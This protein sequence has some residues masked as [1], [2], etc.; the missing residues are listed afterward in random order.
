MHD[1][2]TAGGPG[3][4][5]AHRGRPDAVSEEPLAAAQDHGEDNQAVG[6]D[7][8]LAHEGAGQ[9]AAAV[10]LQFPTRR[11][12]EFAN[13]MCDVTA[14]SHRTR[15]GEVFHGGGHDML[16]EGVQLAADPVAGVGDS[17]PEASHRLVGPPAQQERVR[18]IEDLVHVLARFPI[19]VRRQ[20]AAKVE[21]VPGILLGGAGALH[22]AVQGQEGGQCQSH[23]FSFSATG[24]TPALNLF[25]NYPSVNRHHPATDSRCLLTS[26]TERDD[27]RRCD[28]NGGLPQRCADRYTQRRRLLSAGRR[29][30]IPPVSRP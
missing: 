5:Q 6:V 29:V 9:G 3:A 7:E 24:S 8:V 15:P 23:D 28:Q 11:A 17:G 27:R 26:A 22:D 25:T 14:E 20:P 18:L 21:A 19:K 4:C 12:L 16:G 10:D 1:H 30:C 2:A 13:L